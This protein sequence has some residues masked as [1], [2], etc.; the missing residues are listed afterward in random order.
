MV[1]APVAPSEA[2]VVSVPP[3]VKR[4]G[5]GR[6]KRERT[7]SVVSGSSDCGAG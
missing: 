7:D 1:I 4:A 5:I 3:R 2:S 6:A